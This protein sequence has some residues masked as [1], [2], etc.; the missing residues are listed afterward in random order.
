LNI[1]SPATML[2]ILGD[3]GVKGSEPVG[4]ARGLEYW[5]MKR[6]Y[7]QVWKPGQGNGVS[8]Y[9]KY[10]LDVFMGTIGIHTNLNLLVLKSH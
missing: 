9:Q 5:V 7:N 8:D 2:E 6:A 1:T 4:F 10:F 3:S